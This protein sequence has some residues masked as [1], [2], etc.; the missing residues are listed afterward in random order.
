MKLMKMMNLQRFGVNTPVDPTSSNTHVSANFG[1]LLY[2]GLNK[3][4]FE[5]YDEIPEQFSKV[6]NVK[7]S[8]KATETDYGLGAFG[9]WEERED[10]LDVVAYAKLSTSGEVTYTH[11]EFTKGFM[12]GRKLYDDEQYNQIS[13]FAK[14][15]A[16][17]GRAKVE[18]DAMQP[19]LKGFAGDSKTILGRDGKA[20]FATDHPLVDASGVITL[21]TITRN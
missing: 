14:A 12:I 7:T 2:P 18:K 20:L 8:N 17:A 1:K 9:D 3:I 10:E 16:R 21:C 13:K 4:F 19:L 15:L 6:Y 5:T 11:K